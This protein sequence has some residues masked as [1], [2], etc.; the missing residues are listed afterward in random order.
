M[1]RCADKEDCFLGLP[2]HRRCDDCDWAKSPEPAI[3]VAIRRRSVI[4]FA[5]GKRYGEPLRTAEPYYHGVNRAGCEV[6]VAWQTNGPCAPSEGS[7][8]WRMFEVSRIANLTLN[9]ATFW[10]NRL[11]FSPYDPKPKNLESVHCRVR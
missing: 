9:G 1:P 5:Y 7:E 11:T 2:R 4:R 6:L 8:G 10:S 3:C